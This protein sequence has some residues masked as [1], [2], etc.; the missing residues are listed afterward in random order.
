MTR[1]KPEPWL[2]RFTAHQLEK[3]PSI[4]GLFSGTGNDSERIDIFSLLVQDKSIAKLMKAHKSQI[5]RD[6]CWRRHEKLL[7]VVV[8]KLK[9][10]CKDTSGS[11]GDDHHKPECRDIL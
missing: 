2:V 7:P 1:S 9:I 5:I 8:N 4:L 11:K 3:V 10:K 6:I